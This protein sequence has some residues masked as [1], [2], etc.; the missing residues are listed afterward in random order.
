MNDWQPSR[1]N[2]SAWALSHQTLILFMII[3]SVLAG[4]VAYMSLGRAED[5]PFT[6]KVMTV[7]TEWP[8][9]TAREVEQLVTDPIEKKLEEVPFYDYARSYSRP[10]ESIVFLS[11]KDSTPPARVAEL[12][13]Q[14]RKKVGDIAGNLPHGIQGPYFNDEFGDVYSAIYGFSGKDFSPD[15]LKKIVE[16]TRERLLRVP[17]VEKADLIAE[18]E[19]K[20][21]VEISSRR[22]ATYGVSVQQVIDAIQKDNDVAASGNVDVGADRVFVRVDVG[23]DKAAS[24]RAAP[25]QVAGK[26]LTVGDVAEIKRGYVDPVQY[27]MRVNGHDAIGLGIVMTKRDDVLSLGKRLDAEMAKITADLPAGVTIETVADQPKVVKNSVNEF[28]ESLVEALAIVM[29]VS[30]LSLGWRTG[31]VVALAVP[32]VLALTMVAMLVLGIDLQRISLGALIIALGLLVDDA[33]IAVE[34][35]VVKMEQGWDRLKAG[36]YA[37]ASTALPMLTGTIVTAAGFVPVGFAASVAGEYTNSIFW[38]VSVSLGISWI[39]AVLF[40]P[41]LGQ[42][43]LPA[44]KAHHEVG[45]VY[46]SRF[47][48]L[49]RGL[50]ER[51]VRARW[52]TIGVTV[53]LFVS[54]IVAFGFVQQQFFPSANRPELFVDIRL[55]EGSSYQATNQAVERM[56]KLLAKN[57]NV[58]S[59]VSYI[60]GGSPR[61]YLPMD[62][63]LQDSNFAQLIVMSKGLKERV[64]LQKTLNGL[65][66]TE[67]PEARI[68]VSALENGPPVGYPVQFRVTGGDPTKLREYA[69]QVRD[70]MRA[71]P[72]LTNVQLDWDEMAKRIRV[73]VDLTKARALG[74]AKQDLANALQT[75]LTGT[76]VTQYRE[77]TELIDVVLRTPPAERYDLARLGDLTIGAAG[78]VAIPLSQVAT[79]HYELEDPILWRR[80]RQTTMI[81]R[82]D[83]GDSTQAPVVSE[84]IE[85]QLDALRAKLPDGYRID[86]GGAIEESAKGNSSLIKMMPL[87]VLIMVTVMMVQLQ[88]F[89]RLALVLLT[90]PLGII[91]VAAAL[92]ISGLPFGFVALLGVIA[93]AGI[94]MRNSIILVDQIR[95]DIEDGH[96]PWHAVIDATVRRS[97]PIALTAAAAILAMVPLASSPFWG[98]MAVA[99]MGGLTG[100]T[101]LTIF[102]LPALYAAFF[103]VRPPKEAEEQ[104][105][106]PQTKRFALTQ[107]SA[108][109]TTR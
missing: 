54:A 46:D 11:L 62:Q 39:V 75:A 77:G 2:I 107:L 89:A 52:V 23:F 102:F 18:Q 106:L 81:A 80:S 60:G 61:F 48:R 51:T 42:H 108:P 53:G 40:T 101:F 76:T 98:P 103:N 78:G 41:Y 29:A 15:Q 82:A 28:V 95:Q 24:V 109:A 88:S 74:I 26:Q 96:T 58:A 90:A 68:R 32:L 84:Q 100:A 50:I 17:G 91:G 6:F 85:P 7:R 87:M 38:V 73:E 67:F 43:L 97:R 37:Y 10:G 16:E 20:I 14:A 83:V 66:D 79:L 57:E 94:I 12:W 64:A 93:L 56:E 3:A 105:R 45:D 4:V 36:A 13:Y 104:S 21:Y 86:M 8:G 49:I 99:I 65:A 33:I 30:F 55:A 44:P 92:L 22:L 47:Y 1:G 70:I 9:A 35:M 69:Y 27:A 59:W 72:H 71:N 34:M 25:L 31:I 5:P 63:Q 19:Q